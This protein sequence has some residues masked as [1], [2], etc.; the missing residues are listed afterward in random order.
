TNIT[1]S[2]AG[3]VLT[4]GYTGTLSVARGGTGAGTA[5]GARTNLGAAASGANSDITSL[6]GLT[7]ALSVAQGGTGAA[8]FTS[9]GV[10]F[11]NAAGAL[12]ATAAGTT[13][14]CLIGNTAS[15]PTFSSCS[16]AAAGA[17]PGG[18]AGGDLTGTYPN[19]TI[20]KI[21]GTTVTTSSVASGNILQYNGTA[22]VNQS[23]SGDVTLSSTA[24]A[25]IA[26][27]AVTGTKIAS[28]T[29]TGANIAANT[30]ANG[31][32]VN[33]AVTVTAGTGLSG[34]G[35]VALGAST[36]VNIANTTVAANSYGSASS[37]ATFTVNGQGQ[38][39][40]AASTAIAIAATQITSGNYVATL[41]ALTGLTTTGNS[42]TGST[43]TLS[44]TYG[45]GAN[46][47]AQGNTSLSFTGTGN[48]T[49]A[50][51][52]TAG[53]GF[54]TTTLTVVSNPSFSGLVSA[55]G[56]LSVA[57]ATSFTNAGST[58]NTAIAISDK[59]AG[60]AI[61]TAAAT[62]DAST[63]FNV[64]QTTA[65]QTLSLPSPTTTTAGR[66]V[67]VNNVGTSSF[68]MGGLT[69]NTAQSQGFEW[70]GTAWVQMN[71]TLAGTGLTQ[72]GNII[73]SSAATSV[74]NDTNITGSISANVLT[75]GFTGTLSVARGG[76][77]SGTAAGA[78]TNLGAAASGANSDITS[79]TGLTTALSV[80]QGGTG[81][82]SFTSN[83][84][85]YGNGTGS[86]LV[87]AA[88]TTGQ[89]LIGN[90]GAAPSFSSCSAAAGGA[91]PGGAAGG[92]L[93]GTYPNPTIAK[94][95][96]TTLT[97]S[98]VASGN[99]LQYNGTAWVNQ[100]VS[101]DITLSSTAV[102]TIATAAVT[103]AKIANN[104][105]TN[106]NLASGSFTNITGVGALT[107]GVWNATAVGLLY[108]GTGATTAAGARTNLG[109]AASGANSD[110][111]S[112]SGLTTALSTGQGGTGVTTLTAN[113]VVYGNGS[114][115]LGATA[116][117]TT[118]QC[119]VATTGAAPSFGSCAAAA[120][121]ATTV[122]TIDTG[123]YSANGGSIASGSLY[124]QTASATAVGLVNTGAQTFAGAKTFN[125][126]LTVA[127]TGSNALALSGAPA[128]SATS[129]LAQLG[130][131][132][133][134]GN[135]V[136]NGGTFLSVNAAG[137]GAG[138]AA[139]FLNF[140]LGGTTKLLVTNTG[141]VT[142][143]SFAG[144]GSALTNLNGS[145]I[146]TGTV[147]NARLT[148]AGA[149]TVTAGT[150]L[151]G[152]G[153]VALGATT[154]LN[155]ANTTVA[156]NSYGSASSVATF[157]V[158]A[159]G[160]LTTAA[161]TAIA[162]AATQITSG[163]YVATL[164]ALTGLTTTGNSGTGS[165][166]TL[167]VTY[168][169]GANTAAQGN[170]ALSY[171]GTGNLT[172]AISG[173]AG[174]GFTTTTL[175]VVNNPSFSGLVS[176]NGGLTVATSN[177]FTNAGAT[178]NTAIAISDKAA[179]G[180]IGT[181]AATVDAATTFNI[182]Q[183]TSGQTLSLPS[184]TTTTAGRIAYV[185]NVGTTSFL[186]SG[187]TVQA[188]TTQ[189]FEWN[190]TAWVAMNNPVAGTGL[191]QSGNVIN[192]SAATSV[193]NDTNITGSISANILTLGFTGNLSVA[194]GG[195]GSGTAAGARTNLGAAASG[196]NSDITS[197][198]GLTTALSV[199][200]GGTGAT[201]FTSNGLLYGN[202]AGA[203][204][205]TAAGTTGQCLTG[206]TGAA[207]SFVSCA[208]SASGA[209]PGGA[210]GGDLTGT[211][212]NPTIA[213]IQGTTVTTASVVSGN[214][215]QFNGTAF[216]NQSLS[217]D[218]TLS[219]TAVATIA[220]SAVTSAKIADGT[221]TGT[222]IAA[223]T[224]T[225]GNLVNSAVTVT[226]GTGLSGGGSTAL[227]ASTTLNLANTTVA[228]NSYGSASS[229]ATFTVNA[230]GQL[231]TAATTAIAIDTS[232]IT[233]GTLASARIS[234]A[235][236]GITGV[237]T[238]TGLT[239]SGTSFL[240]GAATVGSTSANGQLKFLDGTADGFTGSV[241][242]AGAIA[243]NQT[244][245]LP[246]TGGT[247]CLNTNN[248]NY[249]TSGSYALTTD[250]TNFIRNQSSQ[251]ASSNFNISGTGTAATS[252]LTPTLD[253]AVAGALGLGGSTA[254]S[255]TI[256][257]AGV[258]T[259]VAGSLSVT[260]A[261]TF[262]GLVTAN[263]G[264]T[265][266]GATSITG[267]TTIN[268]TG[269]A[270]TSIGNA[271]GTVGITGA[272]T[273]NG[274]TSVAGTNTFTVGTGATA[275]GGTLAVTGTTGLTGALTANAAT[276]N[277][278][279]SISSTNT[280]TVGTGAT[281]LGGTLAVTGAQTFTGATTH[282]GSVT[283]SGTNALTT[284]TGAVTLGV[285]GAGIVQ[286]TSGGLLS[287]G[288]VDRNSASL[289]SG[290]LSV[291]NGG[292][293]NTSYTNTGVLYYNGTNFV[294]TAASTGA[295]CLITTGSGVAPTW[296]SCTNGSSA[297]SSVNTFNGAISIVGTAN[298]V[299]VSNAA[300]TITLSTPQDINTTA[301]VQFG[302]V[303]VSTATNPGVGTALIYANNTNAGPTGNL[304]D[305][306]TNGT[307]KFSV[308]TAGAVTA[309]STITAVGVNG[310]TGL[311]QGTG[312]L[313]IG[314]TVTLSNLNTA[315]VVHTNGSGVLS[316]SAVVLGTDT[317]GAYVQ[318]VGAGTGTT[319]G[320]TAS[321]PTVNVTYGAGANNAAAG[322]NTFTC[323]SGGSNLSGG[324][325]VVTI[326]ASGTTCAALAVVNNPTFSGLI[327][328]QAN[329]TG[330]ALTG[331][332]V[333]GTGI[334][335]L[336]QVGSAIAGGNTAANGG[337]YFGLNAP[338]A[339][340]GSAA[341]FLNFQLN[342]TTKL[343][344]TNAGAVT[345][346]S[347]AGDGSALTNLNGS[348]IATGTVANARLTNAGAL[349]VT[350]G[351]GLSGGGSVALGGTTTVNLANTTVAANSYGSTSSVATFTVN[352]QGQ[353]TTA[354]ST[355]IAISTA[356]VT[357]GN[358]VATLG[359]LTGL[360][361]TGNTGTGS[362][363]T[364]AVAY[365]SG[366]NNA[367]AGA[368]TFTCPSGGSNLSGGG[369][370]VT[371]GTSGTTCA[372]L[373]VVNN[374]TFSGLVSAN[375]GLSVS[376]TAAFLKGT[377]Y[378]TT[379]TT[380]DVAFG[381]GSLIRLTGASAQTITGIAGG[382][383]GRILTL[384]NAA[385]QGATISNNSASSAA[386]NR[387]ITGTG[388]DVTLP[389]GASITLAYDSGASLWRV[390]GSVAAT[391]AGVT[392]IGALD[393]QAKNANGAAISG[394][395][396]YLQSADATNVGI[397]TTAA[398]TFG[399]AKTFN[400]LLTASAG[401]TASGG[402]VSLT[403]NAASSLT[404]SA[405]ALTLTS[406][407][408]ATWSTGAG[409]LTLQAGSGVVSLG[410]STSLTANGALSVTSGGATTLSIDAGGAAALNLGTTNANAVSISKAGVATT[411]NGSFTV[412]QATTLSAL[413]TA[414]VVHTN[415]SGVL[416][417]GLVALGTETSGAYVQSVGAGTGTT[418]GGT[419]SVPTVNVTY[420]SGANT[421][422][423]GN[424]ALT[425][426]GS[427]NLTG[428]LSGTAGGG[429]TTTTLALVNNPS[430]T[431][432]VTANG[433]LSVGSTTVIG[434]AKFLDGT[435]DGFT[436]SIQLAGA[437]A[438][439]QTYTLPTTGGTFCLNTNNC[440]YQASGSYALTSDTTNFIRNQSTSQ[441]G[442]FNVFATSGVAGVLQGASGQDIAQFKNNSGTVVANVDQFGNFAASAG[443][444]TVSNASN[445]S[446]SLSIN[447]TNTNATASVITQN[448]ANVALTGSANGNANANVL[449]GANFANV[450]P[451]ANNAF[452]AVNV[453]TGFNDILRY[454]GTQLISGTGI[455]QSA[456]ISGTYAN[457][458]G[459][460]ALATGSIASGFGTIS[461]GNNITTT[462]GIQGGTLAN[463][464]SSF[465]VNASGNVTT[466]LSGTTG[467]TLVCQNASSVLATCTNTYAQT[468]DTTNFIRN[469]SSQQ[470]S[471]NFNISGTGT[472]AT[473]LLTPTLDVASAGA[474]GL[475]TATATSVSISKAGVATTVNGS[476]TVTQA[477]SLSS[478]LGVTGATTLSSTLAV[479]GASTFTGLATF[480]GGATLAANQNLTLTTGTGTI[481]QGYTNG[482]TGTAETKTV[483]NS[484]ASATTAT[485]TG[486]NFALVGGT[487][488]NASANTITGI[489]FA[490]VTGVAN[491]T[492]NGINFGTGFNNLINYNGTQILSGT[493]ILQSAAISG[494]YANLTGTGALATGSIASGFG[495][496]STANNITTTTQIQGGTFANTGSSFA[497]NASGNVKTALDATS[498]TTLVCQNASSNL[499]T[500]TNTYAQ[501]NDTTNF[502]RNQ[503]GSAQAT[504]NF[505]ISGSGRADTSILTPSIDVAT[506]GTL[507]LGTGTATA[508]TVAKAGIATT[509]AGS[510]SV[511][512]T[513]TFTG[514]L[515]A[516][517]GI[518][519]ANN[520]A[521]SQTGSGTFSTG[522]GAVSVN[523][524]TTVKPANSSSAFSVQTSTGGSLVNVDTTNNNVAL[525]STNS[526][527]LAPFATNTNALTVGRNHMG[528]VY[529][530]G[531]IYVVGGSNGSVFTNTVS[532]ARVN[533]DGST[534][535]WTTSGSTMPAI[536]EENKVVVV[537]GYLYVL[538][539][540]NSSN[541][542]VSSVYYSKI[543]SDGSLGAFATSSNPLPSTRWQGSAFTYNGYIYYLAGADDANG[544]FSTLYY[545]KANPD[546]STGA[547]TTSANSLPTAL[548]QI[549]TAVSNGYVYALGGLP[550][551]GPP[552]A[553]IYYAK[554]NAD[555][556]NGAFATTTTPLP[557]T[558]RAG[559]T[560]VANGTIYY[561]GGSTTAASSPTS[562]VYYASLGA[563]GDISG[564]FKTNTNALPANRQFASSVIANGYVYEIGGSDGTSW[565]S[566][567]Y[568]ASTSRIAINGSVD[569]VGNSGTNLAEGGTGGSLTAGNT[570]IVGTFNV[571]DAASFNGSVSVA[572]AFAVQG[573][574]AFSST[575]GFT[576]VVTLGAASSTTGQLKLANAGSAF[577]TT[578]Q[579]AAY[580]QNST[581]TIP[582]ASASDTFCLQTLNN[583][584]GTAAT[585]IGA[586]DGGTANVKGATLASNVFYLQSASASF[587]GLVNTT[588]QTFAGDKTFTGFV[589]ST[590]FEAIATSSSNTPLYAQ[591]A[592][593]ATAATQVNRGA[594]GQI[595]DLLQFQ[596]V[597]GY[598]H[599][600]FNAN[601]SQLILGRVTSSNATSQGKLLFA[602]GT[603]DNFS[604]TV[605]P[606][607]ITGSS[608]V[609]TIPNS[610]AGTDTFCLQT[611]NNCVGTAATSI[612]A[613]DGG[614]ANAT[615]ATITSNVFYLQSASTS[616]AGLVNTAAQS[617]I[618][619]KTFTTAATAGGASTL[620]VA[621][622]A[623][624]A[625]TVEVNNTNIQGN[626]QTITGAIATQRFN[627]F[628]QSTITAGSA[629][630]VTDTA[631]VAIA[632]APIKAGSATITNTS[633]LLIQGGAVGAAT[634][635]YGLN[636][637][638]QTG[639]TNNYA[640]IFQGGS[641][642][643]G[644]AA[645]GASLDVTGAASIAAQL[646]TTS[647]SGTVL[648][649][650]GSGGAG[651]TSTQTGISL[652][653]VDS[654]GAIGINLGVVNNN[655]VGLQFS[656]GAATTG[657]KGIFSG[658]AGLSGSYINLQQTGA[659]TGTGTNSENLILLN[660]NQTVST[661]TLTETGN[662]IDITNNCSGAGTCTDTSSIININQQYANAS[663]TVLKVTS[664]GSGNLFQV[665][666]STATA[667]DVFTIANGGS[668]TVKSQTNSGTAFVVQNA[669]GVNLLASDTTNMRLSVGS[670]GTQTS[671]LFV[672]GNIPTST[673]ANL[674]TAT[675]PRDIVV[676]GRYA[677]IALSSSPYGIAV[678]DITVPSS[679]TLVGSS[680]VGNGSSGIAVAGNY[681][682]VTNFL[683]STV[684]IFDITNP[685]APTSVGTA[686]V[687][688][689]PTDI[690]VSGKYIYVTNNSGNSFSVVDVSNPTAPVTLAATATNT[691]PSGVTVQGKYLYVT[692]K[693]ANNLQ[694]YDVSNPATP[695]L[696][697]AAGS[698]AG[699]NQPVITR[700][701]GRYAYIVNSGNNTLNIA[702]IS[703]PTTVTSVGSVTVGT[704][705]HSVSVNGRFAYVTN[706]G[707]T[708]ISVVDISNP[709]SPTIVG[710]ITTPSAPYS[711]A[712]SGR[713]LFATGGS[714]N[715]LQVYDIGGAYVQQL[716]T[717]SIEAASAS[718]T[719]AANIQGALTTQ[720]SATIGTNLQVGRDLSV[721]GNVNLGG[722]TSTSA[723]ATPAFVK[724]TTTQT[725]TAK[726]TQTMAVTSTSG[727]LLVAT[728][729]T[730]STTS[731]KVNSITD[732]AGNTWLL[733]SRGYSNGPSGRIEIWY[734]ANA[735][736]IT[737]V[738]VN[739]D[740]AS[741]YT[742][743]V[744]EYSGVAATDPL[745][746]FAGNSDGVTSTNVTTPG[747][748]TAVNNELV[749]AA[750]GRGN[751][752]TTTAT[753]A[754]FTNL[755][756]Q[757][758]VT[759]NTYQNSA[760]LVK[761]AAGAVNASWTLS[762]TS[763]SGAAIVA[764]KPAAAVTMPTR[765]NITGNV[766]INTATS[767]INSALTVVGNPNSLSTPVAIFQAAP[768]QTGNIFQVQDANAN[769]T[770]TVNSRGSVIAG[771][772]P[773]NITYTDGFESG[774]TAA[775][776]VN[777]SGG[778]IDSVQ[779]HSGNNALH[780]NIT[781]GY[782][783]YNKYVPA[784]DMIDAVAYVYSTSSATNGN[785]NIFEIGTGQ[786]AGITFTRN[787]ANGGFSLYDRATV[788]SLATTATTF[789][790][791][792]WNKVEMKLSMKGSILT[793]TA[794]LNDV[795]IMTASEYFSS[796]T[797]FYIQ[798][799]DTDSNITT[800]MWWD[801][802][803]YTLSPTVNSAF[804]VNGVTSLQAVAGQTGNL[805]D[806]LDSNGNSKARVDQYG[807]AS[808]TDFNAGDITVRPYGDSIL[809]LDIRQNSGT[810]SADLLRVTDNAASNYLFAV[811][812]N[813]KVAI[814]QTTATYNLDQLSSANTYITRIKNSN[815]G[816]AAGGVLIDLPTTATS[817]RYIGFAHG[818]TVGGNIGVVNGTT[819][820]YSTTG[821]DYS[822]YFAA[823]PGNVPSAGELVAL[824]T[825]N[826]K[827]VMAGTTGMKTAVGVVSTA[828]GFVGNS[829]VCLADDPDCDAH[830]REYNAIVALSGQVPVKVSVAGGAIHAGD[831]I[832]FS[833]V[834][835]IGQRVTSGPIVGYAQ[836]ATS[837]DGTIQVL[838]RPGSLGQDGG[839]LQASS[840]S[841]NSLQV[842]GD[843]NIGGSTSIAADLN[844]G[845]TT[846]L[847]KLVV[848]GDTILKG[849]LNVTGNASFA[850]DLTVAGTTTV[851]DIT[852]NGKI[853]SKGSAPVLVVGTAA[854]TSTT[855]QPA[856][857][858]SVDGTDTAG[859]ITVTSGMTVTDPGV[860]AELTFAKGYPAGTN[861]KV[862]LT[863]TNG[864]AID[865]H[866]YVEKTA[867]G[868]K[869]V[870]KDKILAGTSYSFDYIVIGAQQVATTP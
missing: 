618:G 213:K 72:S 329:T 458:T 277:G 728:V 678:Y 199:A 49:G 129:S 597:N 126:T 308:S 326:G 284:G 93:T 798:L 130:N 546:G 9:N 85:L 543:N 708:T 515:T 313:T 679:P 337:T 40:T 367:A 669:S 647:T 64:N 385:A 817:G 371:I 547:W 740:A 266:A 345:A 434:Q 534:G 682:Y 392:T 320:G 858:A 437:I 315:G 255:V 87:T 811:N 718:V 672:S 90:T 420:G 493:G 651:I 786:F 487:N 405:G 391:S 865:I 633:A 835:G 240:Q 766:G 732:T 252:L 519:V 779:K 359:A 729:G 273:I 212:P 414:G 586:L 843:V 576:G 264:L 376:G 660:R 363:P 190:G 581:L 44:V 807:N 849:A 477:A 238:L 497:V 801:D 65:A 467:A 42:G 300:N 818:G 450:T 270:N 826:D 210:A 697:T 772:I 343:L 505:W 555:G 186:L 574:S 303:F 421:A 123:T 39:T 179:G 484:N 11:G 509:V 854:G 1:G 304:A 788:T 551:S 201:S 275:L 768:G 707:G 348:N 183:T 366:A 712:V 842:S 614:T 577:T 830:Y 430:F 16:A 488:A 205:V 330:F 105:I 415:A 709:A 221:I 100:S 459:T 585:S 462:A 503:N 545:A 379:G 113:G 196:A 355:A 561:L 6:T 47:A 686:T 795:Q 53:G 427:G 635:S 773:Q 101:G 738:S 102:A 274:N 609:Y 142:A 841:G 328:G 131:T 89:C 655:G 689:G 403:G 294:S 506:A 26:N 642:G 771:V 411:V 637:N 373:A 253:V 855:T 164:G 549:T 676:Q 717:G 407:A 445:N 680:N 8:T 400:A 737:S 334:T 136:A 377:D 346:T 653:G 178:L 748:T 21:Q 747:I 197:L 230:Q 146:A 310:G 743:N 263:G 278:A 749:I 358:Y 544:F 410:T 443:T 753:P 34:G 663:G 859:T 283:I 15:A 831:A 111:T 194:R 84:L 182:N 765:T 575:A 339:G 235:Y 833:T 767:D 598:T 307:S 435:A 287:S 154:T 424:T 759:P 311:I 719:G 692:D 442:N 103:G 417:T 218:V 418:V 755:N 23:L 73:N 433:G 223:T 822:E 96:G 567:V 219:S 242:L 404:T 587:A 97:T 720:S 14:Q 88:G 674:G 153:S 511:T 470:A 191:T 321:V 756:T 537:N 226:A 140:Q 122:G 370:V 135:A 117:G 461:T 593:S 231:T 605:Q 757:L 173:T 690:V 67:Y 78:R 241:Q 439:N 133:V 643:I 774:S 571:Q 174:G 444:F 627:L 104:T 570:S 250:T 295:Q 381:A 299:N 446:A 422:A 465:A 694:I 388:A 573:A 290:T 860:L 356:Q 280:F 438:A 809:G 82:T 57:T 554:L 342:G 699:A 362:T 99:I 632:G 684:S 480:N 298:Q 365:G 48:L 80:A 848:T 225:N 869:L 79:L 361:T 499:S 309:A 118:G 419:A 800:N 185:S 24:V 492:F 568:Y 441:T 758:T 624:T 368:N 20:A 112:L 45:S 777:G 501:T 406:A 733:A 157:T 664:A 456:A 528:Q 520:S 208:T 150:G 448:G 832:G 35:S 394:A 478:T 588:A 229:V 147:A 837:V 722:A 375:G 54:T 457:L 711:L 3:N 170:T 50:I 340:A 325:T 866:V 629:L 526:G 780:I 595:G 591:G 516:N 802:F 134:G 496:I 700:V 344:V 416:S 469:Q 180:A 668:T 559:T 224:V 244:Y 510:L 399:G 425:F 302:K 654:A 217:G 572:N 71:A 631:T 449:N 646:K 318:S 124:L 739:F 797:L 423:Q 524:A 92:D 522:T 490:N 144:D 846:T 412:T 351:T 60:G 37:V 603:L 799:G 721:Y 76:T 507:S 322:A 776:G 840:I 578:I 662:I 58:L 316:T 557:T 383:D 451:I 836:Q 602:D 127:A 10:L 272:T 804:Q 521:F 563:N 482:T 667:A 228:A 806:F 641:V 341:D 852:V 838:I 206:N 70:N 552:V 752:A 634:N 538:G 75:L 466:A 251:Q 181:A 91:S 463:T 796:T 116:A 727:N 853:V 401:V 868:F 512:Q 30:V 43:P 380:N 378:V 769:Q 819:V 369:T 790:L 671:Q 666:D 556:S 731:P 62:V 754:G 52:G 257:K 592:A 74:T 702:D 870:S 440:N 38:L 553:T 261:S 354:A 736:A 781:T 396:L 615:G 599:G 27:A 628:G 279:V 606:A 55:N 565:L 560:V 483:T 248:C 726:L 215:L 338:A 820:A 706:F 46:T 265:V 327:T 402:A 395:S 83:G 188:A 636:V 333:A 495:T 744:S 428:S 291:A 374:P 703:N 4:L 775:Y 156:A 306:Q 288:A 276:F 28:A 608:K 861:F 687:G 659:A 784:T 209:T 162:I 785:P 696:T 259:T 845:G 237:G 281:T 220:N 292:S 610:S 644:T 847:N 805:L 2:I 125:G 760:Y 794:Y 398:Q 604:V 19:P 247:F 161:S 531:Y 724:Q 844:V 783:N 540:Y 426:N 673:I 29:I 823:D 742:I 431:G 536:M 514:L 705:P 301:A 165:T 594:T 523:G 137:S 529:Y 828:P 207:P 184:P 857:S 234:G 222:D 171:T 580:A 17:T 269:T 267:A 347:F 601:G 770:L 22:F 455:V 119:L 106:T 683:N 867:T 550:S 386:A 413:N 25:T 714:A 436:G 324:G 778:A 289:L 166:P 791:N 163:N 622:G 312:G 566:T 539:G 108:G 175:T 489:N 271:T 149:L 31:N 245:T 202:G 656:A 314:G 357:S 746:E 120:G 725:S 617:F 473:S 730:N 616:F 471:S 548:L 485:V 479:T 812:G 246:T 447:R 236:S 504:S 792:Q 701:V 582:A 36:T 454:N 589:A 691:G 670:I 494:T 239:V 750:I 810:Q 623:H 158:N 145:N 390:T 128:A 607:T 59:A 596:D 243:A 498:G 285:L 513:S 723:A 460:G 640:A 762:S 81:A 584:V 856:P 476:L 491:N 839:D 353:L 56:G 195:T 814:G 741:P 850:A 282:N 286:S 258:A 256:A 227:G 638:A 5:A 658:G 452:Y 232:Q 639:A 562:T 177:T 317:S 260:Q 429:F 698:Y 107:V 360:T 293:G 532:Y 648:K 824:D 685:A 198:T 319:V 821:A 626:T 77:G 384:V 233:S 761:A 139:D 336:L 141:A 688:G 148:N 216:V 675:A 409:N 613:L 600:S 764:F 172:G 693:N 695:V 787:D 763:L 51:S 432:L 715:T 200:Q 349:T 193:T 211:Y 620:T 782:N 517:G 132:L 160:Q 249:Q 214:I 500:C 152:G 815:T 827:T 32:L 192:S 834:A 114:G 579:S 481:T 862:S 203:V 110:I 611:F 109:A 61:G 305:L 468:N 12:Q 541:F 397:V 372:A 813:G 472:A 612:G 716:E 816:T 713:Y 7:T 296:G 657:I 350:A 453:G 734:A 558:L 66:I 159:Q 583:C 735:Q 650:L 352:A 187:V 115:A 803:T 751:G 18:A 189:S 168:G 155:L 393:G 661:G 808:F 525:N 33:S 530:N 533:A 681:A 745:D 793:V 569:L 502:I 169:S 649:L 331:T 382:T 408:A 704:T 69:I 518:T 474:L 254:T 138:S 625:V 590:H 151:S 68:S 335:S 387:I 619:P 864:N 297:V 665:T 621:P 863:P 143:T 389:A 564:T 268:T 710:T 63:T 825:T 645:P 41:G 98:S 204:L 176:A 829:P 86:V 323:P 475:G 789:P 94:L 508:L 542:V 535:T 262:T 486:Q 13:G 167:S 527:Q 851:A 121:G 464:G 652:Q 95:Q 332:P 364:L 677:Y 630:A